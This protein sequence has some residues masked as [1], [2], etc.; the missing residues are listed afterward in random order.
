MCICDKHRYNFNR[1]YIYISRC[2]NTRYGKIQI[3]STQRE[4]DLIL[5]PI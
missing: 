1:I 2:L 4:I 5:N 3:M